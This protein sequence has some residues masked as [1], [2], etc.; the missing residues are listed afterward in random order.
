MSSLSGFVK[1][2]NSKPSLHLK[3]LKCHDCAMTAS[4]RFPK[5]PVCEGSTR[6]PVVSVRLG[7]GRHQLQPPVN[8]LRVCRFVLLVGLYRGHLP[9]TLLLHRL[10]LHTGAACAASPSM[11]TTTCNVH[12]IMSPLVSLVITSCAARK[13]C[14]HCTAGS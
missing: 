14:S 10:Y 9:F 2:S 4:T 5:S 1:S 8:K 6:H 7:P 11:S 12:G 3:I 13:L